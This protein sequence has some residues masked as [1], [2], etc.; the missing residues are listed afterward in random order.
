MEKENRQRQWLFH[1]LLFLVNGAA[2]VCLLLFLCSGRDWSARQREQARRIGACY[3]T[4]NNP[5]YEMVN[6]EIRAVVEENGDILIT[7]NPALDSERQVEQIQELIDMGV[8]AIVVTP[9]DWK[10]ICPVLRQAKEKGIYIIAV[11]ANLYEEELADSTVVSDN[12]QAGV[13]CARHL[14]EAADSARIVL[15]SH[16]AAKSS[17][18]RVAGFQDTLT[19][20][21]EIVARG[22]CDGQLEVAMPVMEE[23]I[24]SGVSFD[25][26][27]ALNDPSALGAMAALE[28]AGRL[29][30]VRVY[31]V[32]GAPEAKSMI[33]E[34]MMAATAAQFPSELGYQAAAA[35]YALLNGEEEEATSCCIP[36]ELVTRDNVA[37]YGVFQWQ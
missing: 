6:E 31:G 15:L 28:E 4:M 24:E 13:L 25:T 36:V 1:L 8:A 22:E 33:Q 37:E 18:D 11:D 7:R 19:D 34:E 3:M 10:A 21:Y 20:R 30:G 9:V 12:Y 23:I 16:S 35:M 14:M 17:I 26:V 32:D 29:D 27:F 2:A 5:Y